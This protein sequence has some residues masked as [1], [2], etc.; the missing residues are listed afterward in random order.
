MVQTRRYQ[1]DAADL[2][3][4]SAPVLAGSVI[5]LLFRG[6]D[7]SVFRII[8]FVGLGPAV[9]EARLLARPLNPYFSGFTIY[10]LPT[11]LWALSFIYSVIAVWRGALKSISALLAILLVVLVVQGSELAQATGLVAGTFDKGDFLANFLGLVMG[12]TLAYAK[13]DIE[14]L[15]I[16]TDASHFWSFLFVGRRFVARKQR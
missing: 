10:S 8:E 6:T 14:V 2:T 12:A 7:I 1:F 5:Y 11:G 15:T 4:A 3:I 9:Y 13:Q 16:S